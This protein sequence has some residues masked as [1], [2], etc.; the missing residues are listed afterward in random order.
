MPKCFTFDRDRYFNDTELWD[1]ISK[2]IQ[3]LVKNG[4]AIALHYE[5]YGTYRL[6]FEY[7]IED[8]TVEE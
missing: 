5:N 7:E 4:Y 1:D 6:E 3:I 8:M 2:A